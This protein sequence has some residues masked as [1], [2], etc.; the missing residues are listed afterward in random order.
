MALPLVSAEQHGDTSKVSKIL[1]SP[2]SMVVKEHLFTSSVVVLLSLME[3][4]DVSVR[5]IGPLS[6][7]CT[8]LPPGGSVA[9]MSLVAMAVAIFSCPHVG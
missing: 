5:L 7:L 8:V 4:R 9:A 2:S 1:E 3:Q 6:L